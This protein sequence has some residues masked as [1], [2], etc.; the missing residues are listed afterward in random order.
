MNVIV[1]SRVLARSM[2]ALSP[3][4][5][6][7]TERRCV[8]TPVLESP[9]PSSS[10]QPQSGLSNVMSHQHRQAASNS[11]SSG[12]DANALGGDEVLR[13][14][15]ASFG[16]LDTKPLVSPPHRAQTMC[17][18]RGR[19]MTECMGVPSLRAAVGASARPAPCVPLALWLSALAPLLDAVP[20][21]GWSSR[22]PLSHAAPMHSC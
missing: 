20:P 3:H 8:S 2:R 21:W 4:T 11:S 7:P 13:A 6:M 12:S 14:L 15:E 10:S 1:G 19:S 9:S 5:T 22:G 17:N 18:G 16:P